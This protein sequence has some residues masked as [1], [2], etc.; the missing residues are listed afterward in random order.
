MVRAAMQDRLRD[1]FE[2]SPGRLAATWRTVLA[3]VLVALVM[4]TFRMP[5][6]AVGPYLVFITDKFAIP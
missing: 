5:F 3:V 4:I 2:A 1:L 6:L